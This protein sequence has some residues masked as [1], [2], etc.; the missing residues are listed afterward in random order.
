MSKKL[1]AIYNS[2]AS[3][4]GNSTMP[5]NQNRVLKFIE[6]SASIETPSTNSMLSSKGNNQNKLQPFKPYQP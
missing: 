5:F 2:D 6:N 3:K 4:P 1:P